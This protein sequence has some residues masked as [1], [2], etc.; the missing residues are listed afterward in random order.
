MSFLARLALLFVIIPVLELILLV[1]LGQ[2]VGLM[3]TLALVVLTGVAGA[4][5]ARAEGMRVFWAFQKE[6]ASGRLPGQ[7]LQDGIAVLVGGAFLLTPGILTDLAGFSLLLPPTR[8]WVQRRVRRALERRI[9][10]G[11]VQFMVAGPGL[12]GRPTDPGPAPGGLDPSKEIRVDD[13]EE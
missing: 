10:E 3:P 13:R 2:M 9:Q 8:R 1:E 6:V 5:L 7:A 4:A 11:T 12:W